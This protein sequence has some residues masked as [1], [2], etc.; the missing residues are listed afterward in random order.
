MI[1]ALFDFD[2]TFRFA[3]DLHIGTHTLRAVIKHNALFEF[4]G[5]IGRNGLVRFHKISFFYVLLENPTQE[6]F[7]E[8][9]RTAY[10]G[11]RLGTQSMKS[12]IEGRDG[13]SFETGSVPEENEE[14]E[15]DKE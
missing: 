12:R 1:L 7:T 9:S 6:Q 2:G 5:Q 13:Y 4:V 15:P 3:R 8:G 14:T 11:I 10:D